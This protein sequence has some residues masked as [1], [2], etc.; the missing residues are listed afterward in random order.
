VAQQPSSPHIVAGGVKVAKPDM[1][2]NTAKRRMKASVSKRPAMVSLHGMNMHEW[3]MVI[4]ES[5]IP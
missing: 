5:S 2:Y 4:Y 3:F 1:T